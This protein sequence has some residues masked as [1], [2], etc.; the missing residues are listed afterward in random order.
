MTDIAIKLGIMKIEGADPENVDL[1]SEQVTVVVNELLTMLGDFF[2]SVKTASEDFPLILVGGG[3][4]LV[5]ND[6]KIKGCNHI[7][8]P[9]N[10]EVANAIGATSA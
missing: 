10:N 3:A 1:T 2:E 5:P 4:G 8:K 7:L 6:A 9:E